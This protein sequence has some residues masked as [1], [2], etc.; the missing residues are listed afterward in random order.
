M[1]NL[2]HKASA[3]GLSIPEVETLFIK[4]L[5]FFLVQME[6]HISG[7]MP[8]LRKYVVCLAFT[9]VSASTGVGNGP[10][11]HLFATFISHMHTMIDDFAIIDS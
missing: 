6:Y 9:L 5:A 4:L 8:K 11:V 7:T 2:G 10:H 1:T 3:S